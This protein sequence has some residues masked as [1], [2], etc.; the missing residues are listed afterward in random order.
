MEQIVGPI[1]GFYVASDAAPAADGTGY[2]SYAKICNRPPADYWTAQC[3]I[4]LFGGEHHASAEAALALVN[5]L[6]RHQID[7]LPSQECSTFGI[8]GQVDPA[9]QPG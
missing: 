5:L 1:G 2:T 9:P 7:D 4:K 3:L 8:E 6:A